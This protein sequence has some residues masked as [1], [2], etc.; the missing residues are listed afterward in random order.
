MNGEAT[1]EILEPLD[2]FADTARPELLQDETR[3]HLRM[4]YRDHGSRPPTSGVRAATGMATTSDTPIIQTT[5]STLPY[6][7]PDDEPR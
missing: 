6:K 5:A 2:L 1:V 7:L 3:E 4:I